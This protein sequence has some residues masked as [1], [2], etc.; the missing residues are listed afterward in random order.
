MMRTF[1]IQRE[2]RETYGLRAINLTPCHTPLVLFPSPCLPPPPPTFMFRLVLD[3]K[4]LL[5]VAQF[6]T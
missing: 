2:R 1:F 4:I 6:V 5:R 3:P